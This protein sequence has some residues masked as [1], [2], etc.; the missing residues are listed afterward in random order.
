MAA[1]LCASYMEKRR[2]LFGLQKS[3]VEN[4]NNFLSRQA[5]RNIP[6]PSE[7]TNDALE[8]RQ[9]I[10]N[11]YTAPNTRRS[12][13]PNPVGASGL[14]PSCSRRIHQHRGDFENNSRSLPAVAASG[15][16]Q[17]RIP[18]PKG[19][20]RNPEATGTFERKGLKLKLQYPPYGDEKKGAHNA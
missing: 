2:T 20:N 1:G 19:S 3:H 4:I 6:K 13:L 18:G 5:F 15:V 17:T 10:F 11:V 7:N 12:T 14:N 9:L 16:H 8:D